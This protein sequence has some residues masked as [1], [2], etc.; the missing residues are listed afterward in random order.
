MISDVNFLSLSNRFQK[1]KVAPTEALE[2]SCQRDDRVAIH[3]GMRDEHLQVLWQS[4]EGGGRESDEEKQKKDI[5]LLIS[6]L[7]FSSPRGILPN[8]I[9]GS[10]IRS[11]CIKNCQ[12]FWAILGIFFCILGCVGRVG[13]YRHPLK[14]RFI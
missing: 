3:R 1:Q 7:F 5:N 6:G 10:G 8:R 9:G 2:V 14:K 4:C 11:V 12:L 13:T